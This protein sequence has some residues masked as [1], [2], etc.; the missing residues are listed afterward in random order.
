[1]IAGSLRALLD[2]LVDYAGLFPPAAL[3]MQDAV[4]NYARYRDGEYA[5]ALGKF[6]VPQ[7]RV[8]EVPAEFPL[9]IL[10]VDEVK[11]TTEEEIE[12][13]AVDGWRLSGDPPAHEPP[14]ANRQPPTVYV[15]ITDLALLDAIRRRGLRAKIRTGGI[16]PDAFPAIGN[17]AELLRACKAKG[18]AFKATAG[19]HHPLRCVKPLTY[20][21][22]APLG[23]M[24]G[25]LNVFLAA[26]L[27]DHADG[28]L[29]EH[30]PGAFAF[31]DDGASWRGHRVSTEEIAAV[32]RDFATSFGSCS[33]EEPINDLKELGWL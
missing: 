13:L 30:D 15:E 8:P 9:S 18:V 6:V 10:G 3:T 12:G 4:R 27:L 22:N 33:F 14:T 20:E 25:F 28:I 17:V 16:T 23:T 26:A 1:M 2:H 5:W 29:A 11:A 31:D 32:R 19:L 21:P 7:A 24:H